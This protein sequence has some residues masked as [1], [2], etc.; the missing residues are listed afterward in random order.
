MN[1]R[2]CLARIPLFEG[3]PQRLLRRVSSVCVERRYP[4]GR[5]ICR[6]GTLGLGLYFIAEGRV[7]VYGSSPSGGKRRL[8]T[9]GPG[10]FFGEMMVLDQQP[11]SASVRSVEPTTCYMIT[12]WDFRQLLKKS[13]EVAVRMLPSLVGRIRELD[14][15]ALI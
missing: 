6:E 11:R 15:T 8:A 13:P 3:L 2:D 7:E 4:E 10:E 9:L 1:K 12:H 5:V 14:K